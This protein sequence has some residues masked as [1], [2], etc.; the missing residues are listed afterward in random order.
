MKVPPSVSSNWLLG[1]C[2]VLL[3]L[4]FHLLLGFPTSPILLW[5]D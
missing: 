5:G 3:V 1:R 2:L 4:V